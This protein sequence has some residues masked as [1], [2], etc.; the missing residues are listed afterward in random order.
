MD[1]LIDL[2]MT[3]LLGVADYLTR[4]HAPSDRVSEAAESPVPH[5]RFSREDQ[6]VEGDLFP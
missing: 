5:I 3:T 4:S 2:L 6:M 1:R